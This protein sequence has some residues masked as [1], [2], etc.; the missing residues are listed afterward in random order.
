M[1]LKHDD[2]PADAHAHAHADDYEET[3]YLFGV[4]WDEI[5][6]W[7]Q[8]TSKYTLLIRSPD[9]PERQTPGMR[10]AYGVDPHHKLNRM[11]QEQLRGLIWGCLT[12]HPHEP[13]TFNELSVRLFDLTADVTGGTRLEDALWSL[14]HQGCLAITT[15]API[16]M[17]RSIDL[18]N[19]SRPAPTFT[20]QDEPAAATSPTQLDLF[21]L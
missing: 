3:T 11:D 19:T 8:G 17:L 5:N 21:T 13:M 15:T 20:P 10:G 12:N 18:A 16:L 14:V 6:A 2:T 7:R 4:S 1:V 9:D